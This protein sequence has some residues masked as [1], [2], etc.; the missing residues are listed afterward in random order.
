M[1][2]FSELSYHVQLFKKHGDLLVYHMG[3]H[4]TSLKILKHLILAYTVDIKIR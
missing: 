1:A 2:S 3:N 4:L